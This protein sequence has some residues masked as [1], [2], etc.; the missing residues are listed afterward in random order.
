MYYSS[1]EVTGSLLNFC[2]LC[3][4]YILFIF[5][6]LSLLMGQIYSNLIV[7]VA[8]QLPF[9]PFHGSMSNFLYIIKPYMTYRLSFS[10]KV[11]ACGMIYIGFIL[12]VMTKCGDRMLSFSDCSFEDSLYIR[13]K[14]LRYI[15]SNMTFNILT[16]ILLMWRIG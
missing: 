5:K 2:E 14:N 15:R 12:C 4:D 1:M 16:L 9:T 11:P 10:C 3:F 8:L 6:S 7:S 13:N